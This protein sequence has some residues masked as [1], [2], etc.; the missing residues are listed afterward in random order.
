MGTSIRKESIYSGFNFLIFGEC[1]PFVSER[2]KVIK[3]FPTVIPF[4]PLF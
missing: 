3:K 2:I 1:V 4:Y